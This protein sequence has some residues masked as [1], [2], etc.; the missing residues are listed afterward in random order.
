[1]KPMLCAVAAFSSLRTNILFTL[2]FPYFSRN[3]SLSYT[4]PDQAGYLGFDL[5]VTQPLEEISNQPQVDHE[6]NIPLSDSCFSF[7]SSAP[8]ALVVIRTSRV[9]FRS[10]HNAQRPAAQTPKLL[11]ALWGYVGYSSSS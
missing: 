1:M 6:L 5:P 9:S 3:V 8:F 7:P 2:I 4:R 10:N 11:E